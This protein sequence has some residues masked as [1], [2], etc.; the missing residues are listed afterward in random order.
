MG[1]MM[2]GYE[3]C[4]EKFSINKDIKRRLA[5]EQNL[6]RFKQIKELP[7]DKCGPILMK[8]LLGWL[9][10]GTSTN[11]YVCWRLQLFVIKHNFESVRSLN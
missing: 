11:I 3:N 7:G 2:E 5:E 6:P 9:S 1:E 8:I 4:M 10:K